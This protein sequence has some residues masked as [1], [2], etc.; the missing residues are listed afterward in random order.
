MRS[1]SSNLR[2]EREKL[3]LLQEDIAFELGWS[4]GKV[5]YVEKQSKSD[6][7]T[8]RYEE[9]LREIKIDRL[10]S[11]IFNYP[12]DTLEILKSLLDKTPGAATS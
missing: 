12:E 6:L 4:Q 3:G 7:N 11:L 10:R 1:I 9:L 5:S 2:R 8:R